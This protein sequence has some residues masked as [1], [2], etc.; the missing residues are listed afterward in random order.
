MG[1]QTE[2]IHI[3]IREDGSRV[4]SRDMEKLG[5]TASKVGSQFSA[6]KAT[7]LGVIT[8]AALKQIQ[9]LADAY[10]TIQNRLRLTTI[11]QGN[12]NAVFKELNDIS[13]RTRSSLEGNVELYS[14]MSLA[15]KTLGVSQAEVLQFTES[16]NKA[17]KISGA[18][19]AEAE[20]GLR[21]L[22]QGLASGALRGDELNSVMENL[23]AIADVIAK[24]LGITRG[25]LRKMGQD[26]K[27]SGDIILKAFRDARVELDEKFKTTVP[28]IAE[29]F[30][31]FKNQLINTVGAL[32]Q[33]AGGSSAVGS[34]FLSVTNILSDLTP[35]LVNI[36]R[37]ITGSL[38]PMDE[39]SDTAKK[40]A[41]GFVVVG[42]VLTSV[43]KIIYTI[44]VGAFNAV[45]KNIE[46]IASSISALFNG[47]FAEA[48]TILKDRFIGG[49]SDLV[50]GTQELYGTLLSDTT[51]TIEKIDKIWDS[52]KRDKQDRSKQVMGAISTTPGTKGKG[53]GLS[54][55]EIAKQQKALERLGNE[56]RGVLNDIDPLSGAE[57]QLAKDQQTLVDAYD[58]GIISLEKYNTYLERTDAYYNDILD[59]LGKLN[60]E[61]AEETKLLGMGSKQREVE[62]QVLQA[63]K[64]L[65][66][67]GVILT[68]KEIQQLREK[69]TAMQALNE[70][71]QAQ[72][73][74]L[75]SSVRKRE[76]FTVQLQAINKLLADP[77]SG[78]SGGDA[79]GETTNI[80]AQMGLDPTN[81][82]V[83][84]DAVVANFQTMYAQ[85]TEL[86]NQH[87]ISE[88]DASNLR[89]QI[90]VMEHQ[91]KIAIASDALGAI[92]GLMNTNNKKA[93][94]I[95][96]AAAIAQATI[97][98]ITTAMEVYKSASSIPYVG[99]ILGPAAAAGAL[100]TGMAN[101]SKI[102]SQQ[103]PAYKTGGSMMVGGSGGPDS[104][105]VA[106]RATP[107]ERVQVNTPAQARALA[108]AD[109]MHDEPARGRAVNQTVNMV[110]Q[111]RPDRRT[112][113]QLAR[114]IRRSTQR[115]QSRSSS[116]RIA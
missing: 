66:Q 115:E 105:T 39:M 81:L 71:M 79:A 84:A 40:I 21:Q 26:G 54:A 94:A 61:L 10:T 3:V 44:V 16:V 93:F 4:V 20:G 1:T 5:G 34:A 90:W 23:P 15:A 107:G 80:I 70:S 12:L 89:L 32:D 53:T 73:D 49:I 55:E 25:E 104:Q 24:S 7:I 92:A 102:R 112:G 82:K 33:A 108:R 97:T 116:M 63:T 109:K 75:S 91:Q 77:T 103:M 18:T 72:D 101:V 52:S 35:I 83:T 46:A 100:A 13:T 28:T 96:K 68:E 38:D 95:G 56:L 58:A 69:F 43:A 17:I 14:R 74:L 85:I 51:D 48:G 45:I 36:T 60:R 88:Q 65:K 113:D 99:W 59:P 19:A 9:E 57:L 22:S 111:G 6:L 67:D 87:L 62:S 78:F 42:H 37:A 30:V 106:F 27:I 64:Q 29:G 98:A 8:G 47:D 41:T 11:D 86:Q 2:T 31:L 114:G 110:I 76:A 50:G